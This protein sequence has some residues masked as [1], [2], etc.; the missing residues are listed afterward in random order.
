M[1]AGTTRRARGRARAPAGAR[2]RREGMMVAGGLRR[3]PGGGHAVRPGRGAAASPGSCCRSRIF[4]PRRAAAPPMSRSTSPGRGSAPR[5]RAASGATPR[6]RR[7][8]P[9]SARMGST[10]RA[11]SDSDRL[12][13]SKTVILLV[14]GEDRR[15]IHAFGANA[16]FSVGHIR[17]EW[18]TA[19]RVF[20]LGGLFVMP[21]IKTDELADLL[22]FCRR[23]ASS[24][25]LRSSRP[26]PFNQHRR[27][28]DASA[29]DRLFPAEQRRG[30]GCSP[31]SDDPV[32]QA[33]ALVAAGART[34]DRHLRSGRRASRRAA[35]SAGVAAPTTCA[36]RR[37]L[38]LRRRLRRRRDHRN[39][40]WLGHGPDA[41]L[42]FGARRF[43]GPRGRHDG[44]RVSGGRGARLSSP[45]AR[46]QWRNGLRIDVK[47][48][49]LSATEGSDILVKRWL[50]AEGG[51]GQARPAAAR[52][53]DR[54]GDDGGRI[55]RRRNGP[56]NPARPPDARVA[57]GEVIARIEAEA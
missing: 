2:L 3:H 31:A 52:G 19:L 32:D 18:L 1:I 54:Q 11:S 30:A 13:T 7:R 34:V 12:P 39:R 21:G 53:R 56:R 9:R 55:G 49:D 28:R 51:A 43:G 24:P 23:R 35:A 22:G 47:M 5:S 46:F 8:S 37:S 14:A 57:V 26:K 15:Y 50:V 42:C 25:S 44:R 45:G 38:R 10:A 20:Y 48:P 27:P 29:D 33:T 4:P 36:D 6:L 41:R 17:R 40:A 16:E